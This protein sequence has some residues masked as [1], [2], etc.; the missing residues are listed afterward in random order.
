MPLGL[1]ALNADVLYPGDGSTIAAGPVE[2][3]G[4]A[5]AGGER[6][7]ARVDVTLDRG[8][9]WIRVERLQDLGPWAWRQWQISI[10]LAP[11]ITRSSFARGT[12]R[13]RRSRGRGRALEPEGVTTL[14][15]GS[16]SAS[17]T[18]DTRPLT[19]H[20]RARSFGPRNGRHVRTDIRSGE[21]DGHKVGVV[22]V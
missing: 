4:Y 5:F 14:G 3:G 1:V 12:R 21:K 10:E 15:R 22:G 17:P 16:A 13:R 7:V 6:H 11:E 9:S 20:V 18:S 19:G 2:L 8:A